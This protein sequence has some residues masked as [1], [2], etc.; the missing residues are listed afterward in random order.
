MIDYH[1]VITED[2]LADTC[3]VGVL[4]VLENE[5]RWAFAAPNLP[6][7]A[8]RRLERAGVTIDMLDDPDALLARPGVGP[9]T[10]AAVRA[11]R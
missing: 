9:R 5:L 8:R 3:G 7:S 10:V 11:S 2:L 6:R 1:A 4:D